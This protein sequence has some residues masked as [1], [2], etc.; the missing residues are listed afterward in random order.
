[1]SCVVAAAAGL[2]SDADDAVGMAC[3]LLD[4]AAA[5]GEEETT[6]RAAR[7]SAVVARLG[8]IL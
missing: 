3:L 6:R 4:L 7:K 2:P 8:A 1:M 5:A